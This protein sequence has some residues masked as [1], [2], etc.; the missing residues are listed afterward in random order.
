MGEGS[1]GPR[2]LLKGSLHGEVF[3]KILFI[4]LTKREHKQGEQQAE[5]EGEAGS[6]LTREPDVGLEPRTLGS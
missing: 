5:G 2:V 6:L 3:K 1:W 4:Y